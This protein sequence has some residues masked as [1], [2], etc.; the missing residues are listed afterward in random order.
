M[1][2]AVLTSRIAGHGLDHRVWG[3]AGAGVAAAIESALG[4]QLSSD[5][6][7]F[8]ERLGNLVVGPFSIVVSGSEAEDFSCVTETLRAREEHALIGNRVKL[9]DHAGEDYFFV[10]ETQ[11]VECYESI[12]LDPA[13]TTQRFHSFAEFLDWIV[14]HAIELRE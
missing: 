6:R 1:D 12:N 4:V 2:P 11:G 13:M 7:D 10:P 5:L 8:A 3:R 14:E 9:M